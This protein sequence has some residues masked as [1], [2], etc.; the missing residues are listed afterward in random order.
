[1]SVSVLSQGRP[2]VS[3]HYPTYH[4]RMTDMSPTLSRSDT[5]RNLL[6]VHPLQPLFDFY[7]FHTVARRTKTSKTPSQSKNA[8]PDARTEISTE[9]PAKK[10]IINTKAIKPRLENSKFRARLP[11]RLPW[12]I[13]R[14]TEPARSRTYALK[15]GV[16]QKY[17]V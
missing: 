5:Y 1:M 3:K 11:N 17:F 13:A 6:Y 4:L 7:S 14:N 10:E 16:F 15:Y 2:R 8:Y 12:S 9:Y